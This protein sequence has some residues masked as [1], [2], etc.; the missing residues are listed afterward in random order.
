[1]IE[2]I[3]ESIGFVVSKSVCN[4]IVIG[5]AIARAISHVIEHKTEIKENIT[6]CIRQ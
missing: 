5:T 1:M 3:N 6:T 2:K 4:V